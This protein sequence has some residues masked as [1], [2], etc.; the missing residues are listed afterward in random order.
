MI[1]LAL[2]CN[3]NGSANDGRSSLST[4]RV[5]MLAARYPSNS[6][7]NGSSGETLSA[8]TSLL[9]ITTRSRSRPR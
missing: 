6:G 2:P 9:V 8:G 3:P 7:Q 4:A 5:A 1:Q